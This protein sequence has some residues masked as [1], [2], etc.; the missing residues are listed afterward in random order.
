MISRLCP[1]HDCRAATGAVETLIK[2]RTEL[3]AGRNDMTATSLW[4]MWRSLSQGVD[5][6]LTEAR[7][8][9]ER[10]HK[11]HHEGDASCRT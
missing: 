3:D 11:G 1:H 5:L 6:A 8:R 2:I 4:T 9:R 7:E 10:I